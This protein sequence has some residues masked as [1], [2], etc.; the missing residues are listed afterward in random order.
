M[1][2]L[3]LSPG[4]CDDKITWSGTS[5]NLLQ[6]FQNIE[7]VQTSHVNLYSFIPLMFKAMV[8]G[9]KQFFFV[10]GNNSRNRLCYPILANRV[11][12]YITKNNQEGWNLFIADHATSCIAPKTKCAV[13]IDADYMVWAPKEEGK[14]KDGFLKYYDA[15]TKESLE[16]MVYIFTMNEW[17]REF[18]IK[19]HGIEPNKV[20]NVGFGINVKP[21]FGD[22]DYSQKRMLIVLRKGREK[23]KGLYLLLDAME[24]AKSEISGL[25]L[26]I[27]GTD[28]GQDK[29]NVRTWYNYP[30]SKTA[31]LFEKSSLYVMPSEGEPNGIT[32]LEALAN[33]T[34][35]VGLNGFAFP[36]FA[37][38]GKYGFIAKEATPR[39]VA[40]K[41]IEAFEN[42][43]RLRVMGEEGQKYVMS[44]FSW[45]SVTRN[46]YN[47]MK[48]NK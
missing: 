16:N 11:A 40:D 41:I 18:T 39:A 9:Y 10:G 22:K 47:I 33:K 35:I 13:Y 30:R 12:K 38:Q 29:D 46:M 25:S 24:L 45:E 3:L 36:E 37:G 2:I 20:F 8:K 23:M 14:F 15:K 42:I 1:K 17:T 44:R 48:D 27:V 32:Y 34:P 28:V 5:F 19:H 43:D 31:E 26:D 4:P 6:G 7:N 21:Y